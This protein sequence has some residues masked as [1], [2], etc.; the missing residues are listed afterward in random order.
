[1]PKTPTQ[2]LVRIINEVLLFMP[3]HQMAH[4]F[5]CT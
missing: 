4:E 3:L 5:R 2:G 1:M